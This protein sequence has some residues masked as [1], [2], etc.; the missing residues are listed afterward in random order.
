MCSYSSDLRLNFTISLMFLKLGAAAIV[1]GTPIVT[2]PNSLLNFVA[3]NVN[4]A[5]NLTLLPV[6]Y[7]RG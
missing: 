6:P 4:M 7:T 5:P 2:S 3:N 1:G